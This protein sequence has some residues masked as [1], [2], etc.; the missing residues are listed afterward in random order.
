MLSASRGRRLGNGTWTAE[1]LTVP[2]PSRRSAGVGDDIEAI[3][4]VF[5]GGSILT[6]YPASADAMMRHSSEGSDFRSRVNRIVRPIPTRCGVSPPRPDLARPAAAGRA[7]CSASGMDVTLS[8]SKA[9]SERRPT[10]RPAPDHAQER[11]AQAACSG[12]I[13]T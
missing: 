8:G 7:G 11:R 6:I 9:K 5:L 1:P 3:W 10:L 12:K 2:A 13:G 4:K